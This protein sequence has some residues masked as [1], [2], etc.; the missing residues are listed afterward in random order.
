MENY[1]IR[2]ALRVKEIL[3][4]RLR[5]VLFFCY[6]DQTVNFSVKCCV[7]ISQNIPAQCVVKSVSNIQMWLKWVRPQLKV[8]FSMRQP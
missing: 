7:E 6:S 2:I 4:N 1:F 5:S 8:L 3:Q